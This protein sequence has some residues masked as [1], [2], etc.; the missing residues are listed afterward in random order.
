MAL[1]PDKKRCIRIKR[2][3]GERCRAWACTGS[4]YCFTHGGRRKTD[5][6]PEPVRTPKELRLSFKKLQAEG[7]E[8]IRRLSEDP[9]L[10]DMQTTVAASHYLMLHL[11]IDPPEDLVRRMAEYSL[12][13]R[14]GAKKDDKKEGEEGQREEEELTPADLEMARMR[15]REL[16]ARELRE[17]GKLQVSALKQKTDAELLMQGA[18]PV[19]EEYN[20]TVARLVARYLEPEERLEFVNLLRGHLEA[21]IGRLKRLKGS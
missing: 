8:E 7:A 10:L 14:L 17:H 18:I 6:A 13:R 3:G 20:D 2:N 12:A 16:A 4:D 5:K 19:L 11:P 9:D 15:L 1:P 21:A